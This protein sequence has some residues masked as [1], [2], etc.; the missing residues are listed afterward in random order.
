MVIHYILRSTNILNQYEIWK[1]CHSSGRNLLLYL[2]IRT[3]IKLTLA[4]T[5]GYHCQSRT[6]LEPTQPP[7]Q[8]ILG[9][10]PLGLKWPG[11]E[12][13]HSP[14]SSAEAKLYLHSPKTSSWRGAIGTTLRLPYWESILNAVVRISFW[15]VSVQYEPNPW[16]KW[17][18]SRT[19][20]S[21]SQTRLTKEEEEEEEEE[22]EV[23][24]IYFK[25]SWTWWILHKVQR[26]LLQNI[27]LRDL[28]QRPINCAK[29]Q[30]TICKIFLLH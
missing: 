26:F 9:A 10:L 2:F 1:N 11:H 17:N 22:A 15:F 24:K 5:E 20:Y 8:W 16:C 19:L 18:S 6:A 29:Q 13:D 27:V 4:I 28:K 30:G 7:M 12:A 3:V 14:P 25:H 23:N 21:F